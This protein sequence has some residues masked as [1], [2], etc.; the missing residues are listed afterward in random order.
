MKKATSRFSRKLAS[1]KPAM[2]FE[3]KIGGGGLLETL[4]PADEIV[5]RDIVTGAAV[6]DEARRIV[7]AMMYEK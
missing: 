5:S 4:P 6:V 7:E 3:L 1:L 2:A